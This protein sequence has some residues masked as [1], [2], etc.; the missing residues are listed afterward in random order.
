MIADGGF[1]ALTHALEA[2][3]AAGAG[4][5]TDALSMEA[6]RTVFRE[7]PRSYGGTLSARK[8]VHEAAAMA[9]MAFT[10]AGLGLCHAMAHS[11]GGQFHLPHGRLNAISLPAV[12]DSNAPGCAGRYAALAR[13]I[14]LEGRAEAV[15]TR[16][17]RFALVRLRKALGLPG[18]LAEAGV[19]P[20]ELR[21][22]TGGIVEAALADP[23]CETNPVPV[24][25][26]MVR[27]VLTQV[28]GHG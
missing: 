15:G 11:L 17:L 18:T 8:P 9:G 28:A 22:R 14:G 27:R 26:D 10:Q 4:A 25:E 3:T 23:C 7:L 6:F 5:V 13:A 12:M 20:K 24:T 21:S 1:D 2:Y 19:E 16:N